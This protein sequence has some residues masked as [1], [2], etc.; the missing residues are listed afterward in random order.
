M[1][2]PAQLLSQAHASGRVIDAGGVERRVN[3]EISPRLSDA[4]TRL[5]AREQPR[6]VVEVG[7]A[8]GF[9]SLAILSAL[10]DGGKL[11]SIDPYHGDYHRIGETLVQRSDR[12]DAHQ[13]V[14]EPDFLALPK[15]VEDGLV[16][17]LAYIDGMHT[18]DYVALDAF[19][20]DKLVRPGGI[21]AFNDC[22]FRSIHKFLK[23]FVRHRHYEEIDVGLE[24]DYQGRNALVSAWRR[25]EGR[26]SSDRYFRK[27]DSWEPEHNFFRSF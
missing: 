9:S 12:A 22:G 10:P 21:I 23:Y 26:S 11:I 13:L 14:E 3:S 20:C 18:F 16:V 2:T 8:C 5:V 27:L 25:I 7:M 6:L 4:L 19:Y 17:D 15:M 1:A 24:P